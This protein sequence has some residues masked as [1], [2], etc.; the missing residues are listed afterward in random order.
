MARVKT[1][2]VYEFV[3]KIFI[4]HAEIPVVAKLYFNKNWRRLYQ[5][6]TCL[7]GLKG[8][9]WNRTN[10][11][12]ESLN[13]KLKIYMEIRNKLYDPFKKFFQWLEFRDKK[14]KLSVTKNFNTTLSKMAREKV[15]Y[16][17]VLMEVP[18]KIVSAELKNR[19]YVLFDKI[20]GNEFHIAASQRVTT[21][22]ECCH[23]E[24]SQSVKD[25][26]MQDILIKLSNL[27][28][29][30]NYNGPESVYGK[31]LL[32]IRKS[33][34]K[35]DIYGSDPDT[36][37]G[38]HAWTPLKFVQDPV[39]KQILKWPPISVLIMWVL[40]MRRVPEISELQ[41]MVEKATGYKI[42]A[43]CIE[44]GLVQAAEVHPRTTIKFLGWVTGVKLTGVGDTPIQ[45][46]Y[47][48]YQTSTLENFTHFN[49]SMENFTHFNGQ[50]QQV[51]RGRIGANHRRS[52]VPKTWKGAHSH[53]NLRRLHNALKSKRKKQKQCK[54]V[55]QQPELINLA[56]DDEEI[57]FRD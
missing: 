33:T 16:A 47:T 40:F 41:H 55:S 29:I 53:V 35:T 24:E 23:Y 2:D 38:L 37:L 36:Y 5:Q 31:S 19:Q 48:V 8:T 17:K 45:Q 43:E 18:F 32:P 42:T 54:M 6:W 1:T 25:M 4:N 3:Y 39:P 21:C 12:T 52:V 20:Y 30:T 50:A 28:F 7:N 57:I 34:D 9:F 10:N 14:I 46:T 26:K 22:N 51:H 44:M 56:D 15:P 13:Q 27:N 11:R 49:G